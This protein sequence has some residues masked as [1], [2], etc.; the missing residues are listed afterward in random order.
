M[1]ERLVAGTNAENEVKQAEKII[2]AA[3]ILNIPVLVSEQ[4]PKGLGQ[5]NKELKNEKQK[6][7]EKTAFSLLKEDGLMNILESY[8]K[9]QIILLINRR[10]YSTSV[11]CLACGE[12]VQCPKCAVPL[13]YHQSEN[14][15]KC[16]WCNYEQSEVT[17]CKKC[18][19]DA[20]KRTGTGT[21]KIE[22]LIKKSEEKVEWLINNGYSN[23]YVIGHSMGGVIASHLATKYRQ[24]KKLVL[25]A[26]AF[27]YLNVVN[28]DLNIME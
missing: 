16:H 6:Y 7:V 17:K 21:Q 25:A 8:G 13:V 22:E 2:K 28:D 15:F 19:S 26:P 12:V 27:H 18:G 10:G 11:Q 1:Q 4:Y 20:L 14:K 3:E 24:I 23:I 5:T 9:K